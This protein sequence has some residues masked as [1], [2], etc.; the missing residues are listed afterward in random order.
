M[1]RVQTTD[2][3]VDLSLDAKGRLMKLVAPASNAEVVRE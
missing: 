3:E 1:L 2:I